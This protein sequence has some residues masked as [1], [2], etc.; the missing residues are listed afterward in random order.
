[1]AT[2]NWS[3]TYQA[4]KDAAVNQRI[5]AEMKQ[6]ETQHQQQVPNVTV[7]GTAQQPQEPMGV[8]KAVYEGAKALSLIHI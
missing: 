6:F 1:M 7:T 3:D 8:G 2:D 5:L 4:N